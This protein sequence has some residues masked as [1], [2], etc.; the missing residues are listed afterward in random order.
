MHSKNSNRR[1]SIDGSFAFASIT[2]RRRSFQRHLIASPATSLSAVIPDLQSTFGGLDHHWTLPSSTIVATTEANMITHTSMSAL[3]SPST[4]FEPILNVPALVTFV[5]IASVFGALIVRTNQVEAAV[6]ERNL[7]LQELRAYKA[8]QLDNSNTTATA[9]STETT[10]TS[11]IDEDL[12]LC[13]RRY[14]EAVQ[15][16]ER[17]RNVLPGTSRIRIV[18]PSGNRPEELQA[19]ADARRFLGK[20]YDIGSTTASSSSSS[21]PGDSQLSSEQKRNFN[22]GNDE[23]GINHNNNKS[24]LPIW[25]LAIVI[26][27]QLVLL[28]FLTS[29]Q[30]VATNSPFDNAG[31]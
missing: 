5:F 30:D 4:S 28:G 31:L 18:A 15:R 20:D 21:S 7:R 22:I 26:L 2:G 23:S 6:Q 12:A 3:S 9:G 14:E 16:E 17:L 1:N 25:P 29:L 8:R 19:R 11:T 27:S 13:L 24:Q 10:A